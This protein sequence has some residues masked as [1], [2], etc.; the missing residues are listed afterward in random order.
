MNASIDA[1]YLCFWLIFMHTFERTG[2]EHKL[3]M[4]IINICKLMSK[5]EN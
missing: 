3:F 2:N 5:L 1:N 4:Y